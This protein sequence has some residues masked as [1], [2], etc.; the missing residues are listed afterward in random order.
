MH[1]KLK[2]KSWNSWTF[3][4]KLVVFIILEFNSSCVAI[5]ILLLSL[6]YAFLKSKQTFSIDTEKRL[7]FLKSYKEFNYSLYDNKLYLKQR[8][9]IFYCFRKPANDVNGYN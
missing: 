3:E 7:L 6:Q 9:H 2:E 8:S 5:D 4:K 1:G